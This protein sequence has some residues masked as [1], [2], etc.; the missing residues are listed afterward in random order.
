[1]A[2]QLKK[3][4]QSRI[5]NLEMKR[6]EIAAWQ[7]VSCPND[8]MGRR[9][10]EEAVTW[11]CDGLWGEAYVKMSK[12]DYHN[13]TQWKKTSPWKMCLLGAALYAFLGR[14]RDPKTEGLQNMDGVALFDQR[15]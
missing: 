13:G 4:Y 9:Y 3:H 10:W 8:A 14:C 7:M 1:M 15:F 5:Q 11:R 2:R 6:V 12:E